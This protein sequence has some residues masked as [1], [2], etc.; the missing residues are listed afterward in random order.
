V[1]KAETKKWIVVLDDSD[2][3]V[4]V[5]GEGYLWEVHDSIDGYYRPNGITPYP[6][7]MFR[8]AA[9]EEIENWKRNK[10]RADIP[11]NGKKKLYKFERFSFF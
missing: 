11:L 2:C 6:K 10:Q 3:T 4:G 9:E 1:K 8:D 5:G 7:N